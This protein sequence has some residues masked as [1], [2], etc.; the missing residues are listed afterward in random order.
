GIVGAR[1][2]FLPCLRFRAHTAVQQLRRINPEEQG[3]DQ[4]NN[5]SQTAAAEHHARPEAAAK[6]AAA[7]AFATAV[8]HIVGGAKIVQAH[9]CFLLTQPE[10][11]LKPER[12]RRN[13]QYSIPTTAITA[14]VAA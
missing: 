3:Q 12:A 10:A 4:D 13:H 8:F 5:Q 14:P 7:I 2:A 9:A 11:R 6:S 1:P